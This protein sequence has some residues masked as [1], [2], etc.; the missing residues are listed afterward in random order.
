[1][2]HTEKVGNHGYHVLRL[3]RI[4]QIDGQLDL[5]PIREFDGVREIGDSNGVLRMSVSELHRSVPALLDELRLQQVSLSQ[6]S[7]HHATLRP[8]YS[9]A[10]TVRAWPR[11]AF[12]TSSLSHG[13]IPPTRGSEL[14]GS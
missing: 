3:R 14:P 4:L 6:L 5:E 7:T 1:M 10:G 8:R 13:P 9:S 11:S 12:R 2:I